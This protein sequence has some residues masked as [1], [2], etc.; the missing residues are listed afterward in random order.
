MLIVF[1]D[2]KGIVQHEFVPPNTMVNFDIYCDDLR[3]LR[4]NVQRKRPELLRSHSWLLHHDVPT[5]T[6]MKTTEFVT[7]NNMVIVPP[8]SL[9]AGLRPL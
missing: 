8:S 2:V 5:H 1:S 3:C 4:E 9:L 7:N 6:F